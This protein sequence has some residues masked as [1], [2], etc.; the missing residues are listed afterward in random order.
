MT[1]GP[2]L[3]SIAAVPASTRCSAALSATLYTPNHDAPHS[4]SS[5]HS[6]PVGAT[7]R[8]LTSSTTPS[9]SAPTT[10]RPSASEPAP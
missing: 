2:T 9:A 6:R 10:S 3:T 7:Q 1:M 8:R 4:A 5:A